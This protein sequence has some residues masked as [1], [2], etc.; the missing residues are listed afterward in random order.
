MR[1]AERSAIESGAVSGLSLMERAGR[2]VVDAILDE[3]PELRAAPAVAVVLCGP[4]NNGGD[5]FVIA[6]LLKARG[7]QVHVFMFGAAERLPLD[8]RRNCVLWEELGPVGAA[9]DMASVDDLIALGAAVFID[10]LFGTGLSRPV[11]DAP[12]LRSFLAYARLWGDGAGP[13]TV[14]V[15]L[16][17]GMCS[18]SGRVLGTAMPAALTVTFHRAKIGHFLQPDAGWQPDGA[19]LCGKLRLVDIGLP[20][21]EEREDPAG[22]ATE[23]LRT[24]ERPSTAVLKRPGDGHKYSHGHAL[25]ISGGAGRTGAARLAARGALRIGAGLVTLAVP[26]AALMEC[27]CHVTAVML[28]RCD[29]A[30]TLAALLQDPRLNALCVGPGMGLS[31]REGELVATV[32][33]AGRPTVLDADALTLVAGDK[34]LF[35]ALHPLCVLTPHGGE[36]ARLFPDIAA[37][38]AEPAQ[39]GPAYSRVDAAREAARLAGCIVLMKGP[40]TV[41]AAPDG[42]ASIHAALYDRAVPWLATAGAGDV[43]AGMIAGLLARGLSPYPAA[44]NAAWLHAEAAR[45][46]G[47]G[48]IAEDLPEALPG[49]LQALAQGEV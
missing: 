36:F 16:P 32:L 40:D 46:F 7:W 35:S 39:H 13:P 30:E 29:E 27:A 23:S 26:G 49:V 17:S 11:A 48:L 8:A 33:A 21:P 38:L 18:D 1:A 3:W 6:R 43:L 2:G 42:Q 15:D 5:G 4:G 9:A 41:I 31:D 45:R 44:R 24:V 20:P 47:A 25:V 34:A 10:A 22:R 28:R 37:R 14:A 12:P 19:G